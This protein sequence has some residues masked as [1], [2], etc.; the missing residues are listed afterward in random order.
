MPW[1]FLASIVALIASVVLTELRAVRVGDER[2]R[3][4]PGY[5][6]VVGGLIVI[7]VG[8]AAALSEQAYVALLASAVGLGAVVIGVTRQPEATAH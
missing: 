1:V 6:L 4:A 3:H 2:R 5:A 7:A 8:I